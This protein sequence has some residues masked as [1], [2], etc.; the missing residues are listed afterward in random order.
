MQRRL[1]VM[2]VLAIWAL[3]GFDS[4]RCSSA[5][6]LMAGGSSR[7]SPSRTSHTN[8]EEK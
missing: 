2:T 7:R 5:W 8:W 6:R 4:R 3:R 1:S